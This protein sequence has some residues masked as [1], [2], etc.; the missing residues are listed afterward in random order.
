MI[1]IKEFEKLIYKGMRWRYY[2]K[3]NKG[4][5]RLSKNEFSH[6]WATVIFKSV[7]GTP[8]HILCDIN[9]TCSRPDKFHIQGYIEYLDHS[10]ETFVGHIVW[11]S[12]FNT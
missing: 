10:R 3:L 5:I 9:Y 4:L 2:T 11:M 6:F 12:K 8:V 1:Q 7:S